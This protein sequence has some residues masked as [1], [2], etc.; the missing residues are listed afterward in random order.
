VNRQRM[1]ILGCGVVSPVAIGDEPTGT[2]LLAGRTG[3]G[4]VSLFETDGLRCRLAAEVR[5]FDPHAHLAGKSLRGMSRSAHLACTAAS[6]A[7]AQPDGGERRAGRVGLVAGTAFGNVNSMVRFDRESFH[8]GPRFVDAMLFPNTVINSPAG[9]ISIFFG[10]T[11]PNTTLSEG[12]SSGLAAFD[13]AAS[14]LDR[15]AADE[16]LA[17]GFEELSQWLYLGLHNSGRLA[18]SGIDSLPE[19]IP[20][21]PRSTGIVYGEGAAFLRLAAEG[22]LPQS[23]ADGHPRVRGW[24]TGMHDAYVAAGWRDRD[25]RSDHVR[26]AMRR[27]MEGAL[28]AAGLIPEDIGGVWASASG[29]PELDADEAAVLAD[30][31]GAHLPTLPIVAIK[32]ALGESFGASGALQVASAVHALEDGQA[33]PTPGAGAARSELPGL[34]NT[35]QPLPARAILVNAF[36]GRGNNRSLVVE[37]PRSSARAGDGRRVDR[38]TGAD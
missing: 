34:R 23:G 19:A 38:H 4:E 35:P 1:A 30:L 7:L 21:D 33:P 28:E 9:F 32:A 13:Y 6:L 17:G 8:E 5:D 18:G 26:G 37:P 36:N 15:G 2:A 11:G 10:L 14:V 24:I 29:S 27:A 22:A 12:V 31:F 3:V 25:G 20:F 16:V